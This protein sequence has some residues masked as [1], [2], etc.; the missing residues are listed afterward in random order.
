MFL[1][2]HM[3]VSTADAGMSDEDPTRQGEIIRGLATLQQAMQANANEIADAVFKSLRDSG[4]D[5]QV[6]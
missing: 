6:K 5:M 3:A 2:N 4:V 1:R